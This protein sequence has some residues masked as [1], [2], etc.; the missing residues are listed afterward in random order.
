MGTLGV[1]G[2]FGR[3]S[4]SARVFTN[5]RRFLL[6]CGGITCSRSRGPGRPP[7]VLLPGLSIKLPDS[8]APNI[9][10]LDCIMC[11]YTTLYIK[12]SFF[13][14]FSILPDHTCA[15]SFINK[16]CFSS[17]LFIFLYFLSFNVL[18]LN[19]HLFRS[20]NETLKGNANGD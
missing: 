2:N 5:A 6:F 7:L 18:F 14:F 10:N 1:H 13:F 12:I 8:A 19:V 20:K 17:Y 3:N 4:Y 15:L 11:T 9:S 16:F